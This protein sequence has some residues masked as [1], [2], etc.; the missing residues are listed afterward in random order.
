VGRS[1]SAKKTTRSKKAIIAAIGEK[2]YYTR[3]LSAG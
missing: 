1:G 2:A 3:F